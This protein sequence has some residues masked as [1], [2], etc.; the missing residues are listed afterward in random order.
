MII[1]TARQF[2]SRLCGT[3]IF[4]LWFIWQWIVKLWFWTSLNTWFWTLQ[5]S[6]DFRNLRSILIS[7]LLIYCSNKLIESNEMQGS[8]LILILE[9][10]FHSLICAFIDLKFTKG[11]YVTGKGNI[12]EIWSHFE[13]CY[14][15][16]NGV[17]FFKHNIILIRG[18][19]VLNI[20]IESQSWKTSLIKF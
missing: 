19:S 1:S 7:S 9:C 14:N 13:K 20:E 3:K 2:Q 8:S 11:L 17:L 16:G 10:I 12:N 4:C 5:N 15:W 6:N 18:L